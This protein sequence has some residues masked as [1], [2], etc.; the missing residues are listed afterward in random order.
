MRSREPADPS[1]LAQVMAGRERVIKLGFAHYHRRALICLAWITAGP[2]YSCRIRS[3]DP[4]YS[5]DID[6]QCTGADKADA[7][8][9]GYR[10]ARKAVAVQVDA[11]LDAHVD[12]DRAARHCRARSLKPTRRHTPD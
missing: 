4:N 7:R 8:Q 1:I 3:L 9:L 6:Y 2:M 12:A 5:L 11:R 10:A